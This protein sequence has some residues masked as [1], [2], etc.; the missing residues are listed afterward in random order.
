MSGGCAGHGG[1][2]AGLLPNRHVPPVH[3]ASRVP[4]L[5]KSQVVPS[6]SVHRVP[7]AG[8]VTGQIAVATALSSMPASAFGASVAGSVVQAPIAAASAAPVRPAAASRGAII[9]C[10]ATNRGRTSRE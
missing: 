1:R 9:L 8:A 2:G 5:P 6:G 10:T 3:C 7:A 4:Q